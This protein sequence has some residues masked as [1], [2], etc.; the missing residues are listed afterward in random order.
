MCFYGQL[1]V[2]AIFNQ[3]CSQRYLADVDINYFLQVWLKCVHWFMKYLDKRQTKTM[4]SVFIFWQQA[5][6]RYLLSF[7][8]IIC[9]S[10]AQA[11]SNFFQ[12]KH[13][14]GCR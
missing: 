2:A 12:P 8:I 1:A 6:N 7:L 3:V 9:D 13:H 10:N 5:I 11:A 4:L 14:Y